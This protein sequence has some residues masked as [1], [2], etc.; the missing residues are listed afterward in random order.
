M[1]TYILFVVGFVV[2]IKG[3]DYLVEGSSS[4]AKRWGLSPL[5]IGLTV[6]AFGTSM[7]EFF[8]TAVASIKGE[9]SLIIST[10]L[11]SN[12]LNI[13]LIL[14]TVALIKPLTVNNSTV[15]RELPLSLLAI[16]ILGVLVNDN[17]FNSQTGNFLSRGDGLVLISFFIIFLYHV[18]SVRHLDGRNI[19]IKEY[20][21]KLSYLM[22]IG[23]SLGL[24]I[25]ANW[26]VNGASFIAQSLGFTETFIGL[27]IL[28][29]GTSLPELAASSV[30][31]YKGKTDIAIGNVV[32]SNI[33]RIFWVLGISALIRPVNFSLDLN[34]DII[35]LILAT[36]ALLA[37]LFVDQKKT[38][39]RWEGYTFILFYLIY[40]VFLVNRGI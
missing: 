2:L 23:G 21:N 38:L 13:L 17:I 14:G 3:A 1:L 28:A 24:V 33:F 31:A 39:Q 10:I 15:T 12:I 29:L 11:G 36:I 5:F 30:A 34:I 27:T 22:I 9:T 40:L 20:R 32:G 6:V 8:I 19:P 35:I 25:G 18:A 37:A 16:I 7:P 26:I 4:L